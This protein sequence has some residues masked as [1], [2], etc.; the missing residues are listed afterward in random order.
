MPS[1]PRIRQ[2]GLHQAVIDVAGP[3]VRPLTDADHDALVDLLCTESWPFH[4]GGPAREDDVRQRLADGFYTS[5][6]TSTFLIESDK[7]CVGM[8][9]LFDLAAR[10][11]DTGSPLFDLR[12]R[13]S[14]R[15]RGIGRKAVRYAADH[16][17]TTYVQ[18]H[19][20]EATTRSDNHAMRAV[21]RACGFVREAYYRQAWPTSGG[22]LDA[23]GYGLLRTDWQTG[24]ITPIPDEEGPHG[25][26]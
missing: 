4:G 11:T 20:F 21:L 22:R 23:V 15:G 1:I 18:T 19:R 3:I 12:L 7:I 25:T 16:V 13:A 24:M 9:R 8:L 6:T 10:P 2:Y 17:F 26:V 5:A 14:H